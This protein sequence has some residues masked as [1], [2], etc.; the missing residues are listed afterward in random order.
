[1]TLLSEHKAHLRRER[2]F[3]ALYSAMIFL[4]LH[5]AIVVY[6]NSSYLEQYLPEMVIGTLYTIS[7]AITVLI[8]LFISRVLH[9][10]GNYMLTLVL[11]LLE[12]GMLLGM[13][14]TQEWRLAIPLFMVHQAIVP[15]LVFNLDVF[16]EEMIGDEE[17]STG[18]KRG[19]FLGIGSIAYA[20]APLTAGF[21]MGEQEAFE[22]VYLAGALLMLPFIYLIVRYFKVFTDPVYAEIKVLPAIHSFWAQKDI[23]YVFLAHFLLQL[24]F[25]FMVIYTPLYLANVVGF[26]WTQ[27][28]LVLFVGLLAYVFLEYPIGVIA[29][30]YLG[31]KEMMAFG[32][33]ILAVSTSW[34]VWL[35][36]ATLTAWMVV[37]FMTRVGASLVEATTESY[38]FKHID[39]SDANIISFF[40][41]TRPLAIV[42]GALLGSF[43]LLYM[44]LNLLF[45]VVGFFMVPG[46]F[47][48]MML[49]D[50]K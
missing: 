43:C 50:T 48:T 29:D 21:L 36:G 11:A 12:F 19:L 44:P 9:K 33:V 37:M 40:R 1:M 6:V 7:S 39:G 17:H 23:R 38:F 13:A 42:A 34:F 24:F 26:T 31:E 14:F 8:F 41:I 4:S 27:I 22:Y 18:G 35:S 3:G 28:G 15:L 16:M 2:H 46:L 47:F 25:A 10:A 32:F 30:R 45:V 49:K 20:I 5:W